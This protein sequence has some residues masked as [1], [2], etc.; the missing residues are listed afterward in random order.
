MMRR[1]T[2]G[3]LALVALLGGCVASGQ[4]QQ[5]YPVQRIDLTPEIRT[6]IE[7]GVRHGMKDPYSAMFGTII[8]GQRVWQGQNEIV[9]C[10]YVNSKNSF[11]GYVGM[12]PFEGKLSPTTGQFQLVAT[13]D[14]SP[15][16]A[17]MIG[18][19][20]RGAGL[21]ILDMAP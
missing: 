17:L 1:S 10:G 7:N 19:S 4:Q 3:F 18:G 6:A 9:A 13:G 5:L 15:N 12:Q 16:A 8:A 20:C 14:Q 21:P 2:F 11:G